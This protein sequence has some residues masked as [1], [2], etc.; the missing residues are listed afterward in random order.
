M[1][2]NLLALAIGFALLGALLVVGAFV[3]DRLFPLSTR[4]HV[5]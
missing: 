4:P 1:R 5:P 2:E 3:A